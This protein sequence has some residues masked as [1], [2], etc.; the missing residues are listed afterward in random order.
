MYFSTRVMSFISHN[1]Q[2]NANTAH[3]TS[4]STRT[5]SVFVQ[6]N[7]PANLIVKSESLSCWFVCSK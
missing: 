7:E 2:P 6:G 1:I 5:H 4:S 3:Q